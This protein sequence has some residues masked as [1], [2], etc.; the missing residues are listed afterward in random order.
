MEKNYYRI[1]YHANLMLFNTCTKNGNINNDLESI[2][3][4]HVNYTLAANHE[5]IMDES[6][7]NKEL[8]MANN[9]LDCDDMFLMNMIKYCADHYDEHKI[10]SIL[11]KC[12]E[13]MKMLTSVHKSNTCSFDSVN[14]SE[15]D[16]NIES[17]IM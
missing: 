16:D 12:V 6:C 15:Y 2:I 7:E 10:S 14:E 13:I 4:N 1:K 5:I 17:Y 8:E 9:A 11:M 3:I